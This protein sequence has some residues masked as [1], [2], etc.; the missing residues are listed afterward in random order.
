LQGKGRRGYRDTHKTFNS[1]A[2]IG[3]KKYYFLP[4]KPMSLRLHP[5]TLG[6]IARIVFYQK[7][8]RKRASQS[9][10]YLVYQIVYS[11]PATIFVLYAKIFLMTGS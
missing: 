8:Y 6:G 3:G 1:E 9:L 2:V 10:F 5:Q 11:I 4:R 7:A